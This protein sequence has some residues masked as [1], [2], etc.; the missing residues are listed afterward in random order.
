MFESASIAINITR[1]TEITYANPSYLKMF[2]FSRLDEL[3]NI[4]PLELFTPECRPTILANVQNRAQGLPVPNSYEAECFR[5][6]G[7]RFS[8]HMHLTRTMFADGLATVGFI[9][10]ITERKHAE[11]KI[12][13]ALEEKETLLREVHHRVKNNL[14]VIIA[15]IK[16]RARLTQ[17][18]TPI[19]HRTGKPGAHHGAGL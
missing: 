15:L 10:D 6:D 14:Q 5:K 7:S 17:C 9:L 2:G 1:G 4:A 8:I 3:N 16:M 12:R 18:D 13:A 11:E 19:P